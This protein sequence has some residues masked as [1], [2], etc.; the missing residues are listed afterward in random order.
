MTTITINSNST[1]KLADYLSGNSLT[2]VVSQVEQE[3]KKQPAAIEKR[4]FLFQLLAVLGD[5]QRALQQLQTCVKLD[6]ALAPT[7]HVYGD[8]VR[9]E[10]TRAKVFAGEHAP[11]FL[12]EPSQWCGGMVQ[13]LSLQTQGHIADADAARS[14]ALGQAPE[15]AG[16]LTTKEGEHS[17]DW[18]VD[19]DSRLGPI[20][21][22]IV[23]GQY[24]W[25]PLD[26]VQSIEVSHPHDLRDLVWTIAEIT[27]KGGDTLSA[28]IPARYPGSETGEDNIRLSRL[29]TWQEVG[30]TG[31]FG[32]GQRMWMTDQ[33]DVALFDCRKITFK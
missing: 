19:A 30:E 28:F 4:F 32:L 14:D 8:L 21:E 15:C 24:M 23:S 11:H 5:W 13:A 7:A 25:L 18:L 29:T 33:M 20:L 31:T 16:H 1:P 22:V 3:I 17:F 2:D 27:L 10:T 6:K 9:T 12:Q 26:Q